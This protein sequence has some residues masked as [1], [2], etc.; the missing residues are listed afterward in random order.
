ML[1]RQSLTLFA[2]D[3]AT[4]V[5]AA[6]RLEPRRLLA[7]AGPEFL[8]NS[9]G[10]AQPAY[11][12]VA[13]DGA[14]GYVGA[15]QWAAPDGDGL[16]V[17]VRRYDAA[18]APL[19]DA[20]RANT[21]T[22][23]PQARASVAATPAGFA[24]VWQDIFQADTGLDIAC[25][26]FDP[27]G[28]PRGPE[29]VVNDVTIERQNT[30]AI[31]MA[32]DGSFVVT[33][34][35]AVGGRLTVFARRFAPDGTPLGG[36]F[37]VDQED[38]VQTGPAVAVDAGG[39][40]V[41]A[42]DS[43]VD[44]QFQVTARRFDANGVPLGPSIP[45]TTTAGTNVHEPTVA[46]E[47]GGGFVV[48]WGTTDADSP[49]GADVRARRFTADG[50]P[51]GDPFFVNTTLDGDQTWASV[52]AH[53]G[54][55]F[56]VAW[57]SHGQDGDGFGVYAR[58]FRVDGIPLTGEVPANT[59]AAGDQTAVVV[60]AGPDGSFLIAWQRSAVGD[61]DAA[62]VGR[63]F[64][65]P[66]PPPTVSAVFVAGDAWTAPFYKSLP[67]QD[68]GAA[69]FGYLLSAP[70][71][72]EVLPWVNLER[73]TIRFTRDAPVIEEDLLITGHVV[74]KYAV[75]NFEYDNVSATATWTLGRPLRTDRVEL[76]LNGEVVGRLSVVPGDATR[77]GVV[78]A[79]DVAQ[80]R[81]RQG[82]ASGTP[83][84]GVQA[85][86]VFHDIDGSGT[87]NVLDYAA[88]RARFGWALPASPRATPAA[89]PRTA[90][91]LRRQL[92]ADS[93]DRL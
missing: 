76:R 13:V 9:P 87:I 69:Q 12:A 66:Q 14:G 8:L 90:P 23:G 80:V 52:S 16:D 81:S 49:T 67:S 17:F 36:Q 62:L 7:A 21:H 11:P 75:E 39:G 38:T 92:F 50:A 86:S 18:G 45:V 37:P 1:P 34:V 30:P 58:T 83:G 46:V 6:E 82:T 26:L 55:G 31:G 89:A 40:F 28:A 43:G 29:F 33:W 32:P 35:N 77:D 20:F 22:A 65:A 56:T 61:S 73:V 42:W 53:A 88:A 48:A 93:A 2:S 10:D 64:G 91:P 27:T 72:P 15:G 54:G 71:Q 4:R 78:N 84:R 74:P 24:V 41:V 47:A 70:E 63:V 79:L 5:C 44:G 3:V 25:R 19:G 59:T 68:A 60:A 51:L 85:H 57:Q